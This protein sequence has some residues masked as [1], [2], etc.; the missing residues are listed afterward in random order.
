MTGMNSE[1]IYRKEDVEKAYDMGL[2]NAIMVLE[3]S[4]GLSVKGQREMLNLLKR[5]RNENRLKPFFQKD[6]VTG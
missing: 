3:K 6:F 2:E 1:H 5:M 4:I